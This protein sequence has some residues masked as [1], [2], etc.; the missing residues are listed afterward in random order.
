MDIHITKNYLI[1]ISSMVEQDTSDISIWV[2][3][4][5]RKSLGKKGKGQGKFLRI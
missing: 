4:F 1:L 5:D 2:R 3:I